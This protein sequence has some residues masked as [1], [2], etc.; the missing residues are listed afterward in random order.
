ETTRAAATVSS[1]LTHTAATSPEYTAL[2]G[3]LREAS[4]E[5]AALTQKGATNDEFDRA[6]MQCES[7]ERKL[8]VLA[9]ELSVGASNGAEVDLESVAA[10]IDPGTAAV[11]YRRFSHGRV[12]VGDKLDDVGRPAMEQNLVESLCAFVVRSPELSSKSAEPSSDQ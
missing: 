1:K 10:R 7:L 6:R 11:A 2:R 9:R 8:M 5:L 12:S 4:V 3:A